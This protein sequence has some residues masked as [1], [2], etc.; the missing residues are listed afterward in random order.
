MNEEK[1]KQLII[2]AIQEVA[3]EMEESDIDSM[4]F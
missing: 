3:P 4:D 1:L 2:S